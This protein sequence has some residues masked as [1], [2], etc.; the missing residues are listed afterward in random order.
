MQRPVFLANRSGFVSDIVELEGSGDYPKFQVGYSRDVRKAHVFP[1]HK[2][3]ITFSKQSG[4]DR[5]AFAIF[6]PCTDVTRTIRPYYLA[7]EY[8]FVGGFKHH[9]DEGMKGWRKRRRTS[10]AVNPREAMVWDCP[11]RAETE[12]VAHYGWRKYYAILH[13]SFE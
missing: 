8:G 3:A 12:L 6:S 9:F 5:H 4:I 2:H 1:S 13:P 7:T 10:F 11:R